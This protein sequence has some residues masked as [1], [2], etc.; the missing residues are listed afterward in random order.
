MQK[1]RSALQPLQNASVPGW[2]L[3]LNPKRLCSIVAAKLLCNDM[4]CCVGHRRTRNGMHD[5]TQLGPAVPC[6]NSTPEGLKTGR[7]WQ[8]LRVWGRGP[9]V[10]H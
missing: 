6:S 9:A 5:M 7:L 10:A 2:P 8:S 4:P 3:P 1:L